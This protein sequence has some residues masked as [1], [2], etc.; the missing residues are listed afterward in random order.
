MLFNS[1]QFLLFFPAVTIVFFALPHR[2]RW[3]W[4]LAASCYFYMALIP[5]YILILLLTIV[6]DYFAGILIERSPH[7]KKRFYLVLSL[8]TNIGI[9][10]FFKYYDFFVENINQLLGAMGSGADIPLLHILLP[11]GLSFH[12][13][14][15]MS[16]TIEIYRG[17]QRAE[18]HFGIYAL[19]VMFYPQLVAGP[20]ER[21]QNI[22]HQLKEKKV[23][24]YENVSA[25]LKQMLWGL[26]KKVVIADRLAVI[27]DQVYNQPGEQSSYSL[28]VAAILFAF[29][30]YCDFSGYSDIALG[31]A[32]VMGYTLMENFR[33]PFLSKSVSELWRRWHISLSTWF[34]D[35]LYTPFV[36]NRRDWGKIAVVGGLLLTFAISGLWHGAAWTYVIYGML[37]GFAIAVEFL[38]K[39]TRKKI[40]GLFPG[41]FNIII[42]TLLTFLFFVFTLIFFRATD[43]AHAAD[44]IGGIFS[45]EGGRGIIGPE[46][47]PGYLFVSACLLAIFALVD[48]VMDQLVKDKIRIRHSLGSQLTYAFIF[49]L[50]ILFGHFSHSS[51][52]YFQ[53]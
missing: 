12:T 27:V 26:F 9:L 33:T 42:C 22:I 28:F 21:P 24:R 39:K 53:F 36:M 34:N 49:V 46:V 13:F 41:S 43:F 19:Y 52:I 23:L 5:I 20:I 16:Y 7:P 3:I 30:I 31:S 38:T 17:N 32:R 25:G 44:I 10:G 1:F 18:R 29:Q 37:H 45:F 47:K 2:F 15:A 6:V 14:Q 11:V 40:T 35:Y 50:L 48:P 4:L 51:F 8:F